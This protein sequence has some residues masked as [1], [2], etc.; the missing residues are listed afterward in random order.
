MNIIKCTFD[1]VKV[2]LCASFSFCIG[3]VTLTIFT[4]S[5]A[6]VRPFSLARHRKIITIISC[7]SLQIASFILQEWSRIIIVLEGDA[8]NRESSALI[9]LNHS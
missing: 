6:M 1:V 4:L 7:F 5:Y 3:A 8:Y 9:I 2:L